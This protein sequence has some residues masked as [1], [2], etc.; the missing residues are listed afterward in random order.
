M[1]LNSQQPLPPL[2]ID[3]IKFVWGE[4]TFVMGIVNATPD[5]FSG[6]GILPSTGDIQAAVDQALRMEDEGADIIDV[7]GEST[8]PASLYPDA[9]PVDSDDD[10]IYDYMDNCPETPKDVV[11]NWSGCQRNSANSHPYYKIESSLKIPVKN[12]I[13]QGG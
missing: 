1:P 13:V 3:D 7:G 12:F 2:A 10:G 11:I 8:R 9:K 5:S 4:R 6:D